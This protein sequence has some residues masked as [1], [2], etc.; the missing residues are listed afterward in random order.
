MPLNLINPRLRQSQLTVTDIPQN[1]LDILN[2]W[3]DSIQNRSL[4]TQKETALHSHFIQKIL[5]EVL[6]YQGFGN[7]EN[8]TLSQEQKIGRG[9]VD[10]ALGN[11]TATTESIIAPFELKGA[12]T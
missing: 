2:A 4:F 3:R 5:I 11:F 6:G 10:V 1:H 9:S 8:W 12:K 7:G